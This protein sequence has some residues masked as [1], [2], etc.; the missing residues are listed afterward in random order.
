[1]VVYVDD[2]ILIA[3]PRLEKKLREDLSQYIEFKDPPVPVDR[4]LGISHN[5]VKLKDGII[6]MT[7][8]AKQYLLDAVKAYFTKTGVSSLAYV[9]TPSIGDRFDR[10][11]A[12]PGKLVKNAAF[13]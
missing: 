9:P 11:S 1:M 13:I 8:S 2:F 6:K 12:S 7:T 5:T 3:P 10:A 4:F